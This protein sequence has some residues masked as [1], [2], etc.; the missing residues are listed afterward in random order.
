VGTVENATNTNKLIVIKGMISITKNNGAMKALAF[1]K[2]AQIRPS[3]IQ[4]VNTEV[5]KKILKASRAGVQVN[6]MRQPQNTE[7][8]RNGRRLSHN[9]R[10]CIVPTRAKPKDLKTCG[11][12][13][14]NTPL[15]LHLSVCL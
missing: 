2:P 4:L 6:Q 9:I 1:S 12:P 7:M 10:G 3:C 13:T 11:R 15:A 5:V 8:I 14:M